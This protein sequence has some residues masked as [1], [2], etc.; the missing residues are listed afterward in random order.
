MANI[1][2]IRTYEFYGNEWC[3][4]AYEKDGYIHRVT[5]YPTD[6]MPKTARKWLEGKE[7][8]AYYDRVF[9]RNTKIY[10]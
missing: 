4:I 7:G 9:E 3:D 8:K 5:S 10:Q 6:E 2:S 1:K